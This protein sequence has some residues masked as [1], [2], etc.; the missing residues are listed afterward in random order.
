MLLQMH[1]RVSF[2]H[3]KCLINNP[4]IPMVVSPSDVKRNL[5]YRLPRGWTIGSRHLLCDGCVLPFTA[6]YHGH[7][8][9]RHTTHV[10]GLLFGDI[11][12]ILETIQQPHS[13]PWRLICVVAD[14]NCLANA[15]SGDGSRMSTEIRWEPELLV[16]SFNYSHCYREHWLSKEVRVP[17]L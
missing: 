5:W 12:N 15:S 17:C 6:I 10:A 16:L 3:P 9:H 13:S 11:V 7:V 8:T 4:T 2:A 1:H 14:I